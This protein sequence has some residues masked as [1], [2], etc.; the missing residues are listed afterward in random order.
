MKKFLFMVAVGIL[1]AAMMACNP[2][3]ALK[4]TVSVGEQSATIV[5]GTARTV[6][7]PVTTE[8][9]ANGASGSIT[10]YPPGGVGGVFNPSPIAPPVWVT[11]ASVSAV[12]SNKA[13]VTITVAASAVAGTHRFRVTIDGVESDLMWLT[14]STFSQGNGTQANPYIINTPAQLDAVRNNQYSYFKLGQNIDLTSYLAVG[15][16]G[17]VKWGSEGWEPMGSGSGFDGAGY[18]ITGLWI[19]RPS[20]DDIGLFAGLGGCVQNLGVEIANGGQIRG[21]ATVG[22]IVGSVNGEGAKIINCYV[23]GN[24]SGTGYWVGGLAGW[25]NKGSVI[26]C[27]TTCT[28]TGNQSVGGLIGNISNS[29]SVINCYATG[30]VISNGSY[31]GGVVGDMSGGGIITDCVALN[32]SVTSIS[33]SIG[34]VSSRSGVLANNWA[35]NN[36]TVTVN[37]VIKTLVKGNNQVDGEDC[38]ATPSESWWTI[39]SPSGPGWNLSGTTANPWKWSNAL[40]RPVL[41]WQE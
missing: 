36:M 37:G 39:A 22:G 26:N 18:K 31:A 29:G 3:D 27:Y 40:S 8:R 16:A 20:T 25:V 24:V 35:R 30:N 11:T 10:W 12:E 21:R 2:M 38:D 19:N 15:G 34:R 33:S 4:K 14:V 7:F 13:T 1:T 41:Y 6:T 23:T 32:P 17:Y 28:V 9:I 5:A